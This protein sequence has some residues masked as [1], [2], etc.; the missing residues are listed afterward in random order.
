VAAAVA[1][2]AAGCGGASKGNKPGTGGGGGSGGGSTNTAQGSFT[3]VGSLATGRVGHSA[4]LIPTT[5][6][7]LIA[8]GRGRAGTTDVVLDTAEVFD[9]ATGRFTPARGTMIGGNQTGKRGRMAHGAAALPTGE[10][11]LVGG[12]TDVAGTSQLAT[13]EYYTPSTG[14]FTAVS[15]SLAEAKSD[16]LVITYLSQG[17]TKLMIAG[18]RK[19]SNPQQ[20]TAPHVSLKSANIFRGD[21]KSLS[22]SNFQL[23]TGRFGATAAAISSGEF[24]IQGGIN[25]DSATASPIPAGFEIFD[26][27]TERFTQSNKALASNNNKALNHD[28]FSCD[29]AIMGSGTGAVPAVFGGRDNASNPNAVVDTIEFYEPST[30]SWTVVTARLITPRAG[31][32]AT[33]LANGDI[34]IIGGKSALGQVLA[35][36][37]IVSGSGVNA[38]VTQGPSMTIGRANHTATLLPSG[39][40]LIVGGEDASGAP[41]A[42]AEIFALPNSTVNGAGAGNVV[43]GG[44]G[45]PSGL[46]LTPNSGP[47]GTAVTVRNT[48]NNFSLNITD[49]IVRVNGVLAPVQSAT[50][51]ELRIV[52]PNTTTGEVSVQ[53]G[54]S[55][56]TNNPIFTVTSGTTG[57]TGTGTGTSPY[58]SPPRIFLVVPTSVSAFWPMSFFGTNFD[59]QAIPFINNVPSLT[60]VGFS[61]QNL[62]LVGTVGVLA[63]I[64]PPGAPTGSGFAQLSEFG[65]LSN[66]FPITV[67]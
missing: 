30:N 7:V 6:Q 9:P 34:L 64:C 52:I 67:N 58:G 55:I 29:M 45:A 48:S 11:V 59:D 23:L 19:S 28:R 16:P 31:H 54:Q 20:S 50:A 46:T 42:A 17:I 57:G 12:Q 60:I 65:Q 10:V 40:I 63:T 38:K 21:S 37:E 4:T 8:G 56:S 2:A 35:S 49:N 18:G 15:G 53:I 3:Q 47:V 41:I 5:N 27:A 14:Q 22:A 51:S 61:L 33:R 25:R 39:Q 36:T 66:L 32:T 26:P 24:V 62:P 1:G 44:T 43:P 13:L